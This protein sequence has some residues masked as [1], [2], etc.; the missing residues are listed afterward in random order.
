MLGPLR[1]LMVEA[2]ELE[3]E[4][5]RSLRNAWRPFDVDVYKAF[6]GR[7]N[8]SARLLRQVVVGLD[9]LLARHDIPAPAE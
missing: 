8:S 3:E 5:L 9:A 7:R 2:A 6:D 1:E 4:G